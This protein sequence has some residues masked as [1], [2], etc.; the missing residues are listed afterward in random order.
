[1]GEGKG[2]IKKINVE[3]KKNENIVNVE[4]NVKEIIV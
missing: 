3:G 4:M 2:L 1:V